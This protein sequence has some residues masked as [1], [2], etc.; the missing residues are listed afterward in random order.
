MGT[1]FPDPRS[2]KVLITRVEADR[3]REK[4]LEVL[5]EDAHNTQRLLD[6]LQVL[7]Q[8]TGVGAHAALLLILTHLAFEE[9]EA[10]THWENI[11]GHQEQMS[12]SLG[13]DAGIR[14]AVLDYFMNI[15][16]RLVKPTLIELE[17]LESDETDGSIDR[18]TGLFTGRVFRQA[19]QVELRRAKRYSQ[20]AAVVLTDIDDFAAANE[21]LGDVIGDRLLREMSILLSNNSRDIDRAARP[22]EDEFALLLPETDR[23]GA[24]LVAE[25][26]R[27]EVERFFQQRESGGDP[28]GLTVSAGVACYPDDASAPETLLERAAQ[29]LYQAKATGKNAVAAYQPERRHFLRFDLQPGRFEVEVL[30]PADER[31]LRPRNL[32][33]SGILFVGSEPLMVGEKV[34][35]RLVDATQA[36]GRDFLRIQ[37]WVVRLEELPEPAPVTSSG[38]ASIADDRYEIGV[39]FDQDWSGGV[40]DISE[41]LRRLPEPG[42]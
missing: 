21:R 36:A 16:R 11:L 30:E 17:M 12:R 19:V 15:N 4:L 5:T 18:L 27:V 29:A 39:A 26:F 41:F 32:S 35:I 25:R 2:R 22:G 24:L 6:R 34:E 40:T 42:P 33:G 20:S 23:T 28:I 3:L 9:G 13:R 1:G 8:E 10:R 7:T 37:G 31:H 38:H 14:V